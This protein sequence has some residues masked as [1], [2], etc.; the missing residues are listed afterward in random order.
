MANLVDKLNM[1]NMAI[2]SVG[3]NPP[4]TIFAMGKLLPTS[5]KIQLLVA[6]F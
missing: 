4:N 5:I 2:I 6:Q 3:Y 1:P